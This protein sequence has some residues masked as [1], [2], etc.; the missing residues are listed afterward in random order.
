MVASDINDTILILVDPSACF[1]S[2]AE[3]NECHDYPILRR[4]SSSSSIVTRASLKGFTSA[5][6]SVLKDAYENWGEA[7]N[8]PFHDILAVK[9]QQHASLTL[10]K[11]WRGYSARQH[12]CILQL[13]GKLGKILSETRRD[14]QIIQKDKK[15][16]MQQIRRQVELEHQRS[17]QDNN[18]TLKAARKIIDELRHDNQ[19]IRNQNKEIQASIL[20]FQVVND[21]LEAAQQRADSLLLELTEH[22]KKTK[23]SIAELEEKET[24]YSSLMNETMNR[25]EVVN[26]MSIAERAISEQYGQTLNAVLDYLREKLVR[27][28]TDL[29]EEL[30]QTLLRHKET[31]CH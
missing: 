15:E 18:S 6:V 21:R 30:I 23:E 2:A 8:V 31:V 14:I 22:V 10:Q 28:G 13:Q 26:E 19:L 4:R 3:L 9:Q 17:L 16:R 20:E 27:C 25:I 24:L 5:T 1:S 7:K 29:K 12:L 11:N